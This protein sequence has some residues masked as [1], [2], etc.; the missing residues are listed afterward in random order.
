MLTGSA[1]AYRDHRS[2]PPRRQSLAAGL[3]HVKEQDQTILVL[4]RK[5]FKYYTWVR[6][7]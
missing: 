4:L 1:D 3:E 7:N 2:Q 5:G 6:V